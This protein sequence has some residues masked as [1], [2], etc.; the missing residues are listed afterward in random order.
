[1]ISVSALFWDIGGVVLS[2]GWDHPARAEAARTFGLDA[3]DFHERHRRA[4]HELETGAI[5]L[6][7]YLDRTVFFR[8]RPF[9]RDEFRKFIFAQSHEYPETRV[10]LEE[11]KANG[12]YLLAALN[13]ESEELNAYRIRK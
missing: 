6:D 11:L 9:S 10:L 12:R 3:D 13:N 5:S 7:A 2:N 1:M 8:D 4:E